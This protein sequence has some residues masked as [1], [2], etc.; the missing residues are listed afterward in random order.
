MESV[1]TS[2]R[3]TTL[4]NSKRADGAAGNSFLRSDHSLFVREK[5]VGGISGREIERERGLG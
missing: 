1:E 3:L 2:D 5:E 4:P